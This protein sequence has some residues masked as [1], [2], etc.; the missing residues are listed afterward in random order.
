MLCSKVQ[1]IFWD[2]RQPCT[3]ITCKIKEILKN[4][5]FP[6]IN[7]TYKRTHF[8]LPKERNRII[9]EKWNIKSY[10][11]ILKFVSCNTL[12]CAAST[13]DAGLL[14]QMYHASD[15]CNMWAYPVQQIL[16]VQLHATTPQG[17]LEGIVSLPHAAWLH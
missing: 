9:M 2:S 8:T 1:S 5:I 7:A 4:Y 6:T 12:S 15:I 16:S 11:F 17:F 3:V 13:D 14:W 10:S